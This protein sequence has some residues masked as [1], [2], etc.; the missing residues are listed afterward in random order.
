MYVKQNEGHHPHVKITSLTSENGYRVV[1]IQSYYYL[2]WRAGI[3][4]D[5]NIKTIFMKGK[6]VQEGINGERD[7][8]S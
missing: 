8:V 6:N 4:D 2:D 5:R 7:R 1:A 3:I